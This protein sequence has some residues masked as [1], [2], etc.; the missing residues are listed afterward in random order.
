MVY[1]KD[2]SKWVLLGV[3]ILCLMLSWGK[4]FM[5]LTDFFIDYVPGYNK[6]RTVTII[7]VIV[8]FCLPLLAVLFLHKLLLERETIKLNKKPFLIASGVFFVFLLG[9]KV[10][11]LGDNY[12]SPSDKMQLDRYRSGMENQI[13]GMDPKVLLDQYKLDVN[14]K[15]QVAQFVDMQMQN[16]E[17]GFDAIKVVR[18][19]VFNSSMMRSILF[20]IFTFGL[21]ALLFYTATSTTYIIAGLSVLLLIELIPVASNYLN[22][23]SLDNGKYVYLEEK[24]KIEYPVSAE[25]TD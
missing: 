2:R 24:S 19:E 13:Y 14:N 1:L 15:N 5:G 12:S 17:Q 16:V 10:I 11:G 9:V 20:F 8:E 6:F 7:L 25:T 22:N 4:N 3:S 23:D 18:E 21:V